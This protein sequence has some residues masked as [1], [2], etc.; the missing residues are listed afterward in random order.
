LTTNTFKG[1]GWAL[2]TD[3]HGFATVKYEDWHGFIN[4]FHQKDGL[5][6]NK[7]YI[8]RGQA[9]QNWKLEPTLKRQFEHNMPAEIESETL[10]HFKQFCLGRRG[11]NPAPLTDNQYWALGQH[12]GL[13]TPLLDWTESPYVAAF[14]AFRGNQHLTDNV[15]V[16]ALT[17]HLDSK[18]KV[19]VPNED[20]LKYL[21]PYQDENSR[22]L[23]QRG[24][25]VRAPNMQCIEDWV[26]ENVKSDIIVLAKILIP[27]SERI[28][29]LDSLN[30]MNIND[31]TLF[32][33]L[34]GAAEFTNY[35]VK[36]IM[37]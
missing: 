11:T 17:E 37:N 31:L 36:D 32:P 5:R 1:N 3:P 20:R 9:S 7:A 21:R 12:F 22:L 27:T 13:H 24:L 16:W 8:Y 33:D 25:F 10:R 28:F 26:Q 6:Q 23:Q 29:A 15:V 18:A 30:K 2:T 34:T 14:F 35:I 4:L 19:S